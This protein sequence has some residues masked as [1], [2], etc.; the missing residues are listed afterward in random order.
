MPPWRVLAADGLHPSFEG[1]AMLALHYR[2]LLTTR[3]SRWHPQN[4]QP[5]R[6]SALVCAGS[7]VP[8]GNT[9]STGSSSPRNPVPPV[10]RPV[11]APTPP[12]TA[13]NLRSY[14]ETARRPAQPNAN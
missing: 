13:Y 11:T 7:P 5:A 8:A 3:T 6:N 14:S 1:V 2:G 10:P 4:L 12:T 9:V